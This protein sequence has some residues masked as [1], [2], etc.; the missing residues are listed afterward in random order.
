[1][2]KKALILLALLMPLSGCI[3]IALVVGATAGGAVLYNQRSLKTQLQDRDAA[4]RAQDYINE[5]PE[6]KNRSHIS[7]AVYNH[8]ALMVGQ[9]QT[10]TLRDRAYQLVQREKNISRIYNEVQIAGAT[11]L[12]QRSNDGW[13]TTKVKTAMV[14]ERGL[15]SSDIKIV[16]ENGVVYL[17]GLVSQQQAKLATNVARRVAGVR[18]VVKVFQYV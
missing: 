8:V 5:D 14:A 18:K 12:L 6:L 11:S 15:K 7:V 9:A 13:I 1:M 4:Q 10:P 2:F 3:P 16:T 17:M